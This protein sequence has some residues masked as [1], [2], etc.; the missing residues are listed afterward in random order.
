M[1][2]DFSSTKKTLIVRHSI[3]VVP[4]LGLIHLLSEISYVRMTEE[5]APPFKY[6]DPA[7]V[8]G[9]QYKLRSESWDS[10]MRFLR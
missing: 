2:I 1:Q 9:R 5:Y 6:L 3:K 10:V 7:S 8:Y 4:R